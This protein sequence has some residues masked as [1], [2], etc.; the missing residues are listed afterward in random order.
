MRQ[1]EMLAKCKCMKEEFKVHMRERLPDEDIQDYM[2][3]VQRAVD[4]AHNNLSPRCTSTT[5]DYLK[6]PVEGERIGDVAGGT[7]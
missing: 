1:L 6:M 7:A 5:L 2:L 4:V 3:R